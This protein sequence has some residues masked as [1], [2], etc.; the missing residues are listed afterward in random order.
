VHEW[1]GHN[2][3]ARRRAKQLAE[4]GYT[5]FAVDM[6]G[7]G[8]Q[9]DH[10]EDA[11]KFMEQVMSD[12]GMAR[13]RFTAALEIL[14]SHPHV[15]AERTG[16]IGYCFGGAVVLNM[17]RMGVDLDAVASFHGTLQSIVEEAPD[18]ID[19][20]ILVLNGAADPF[21]PDEQIEAFK[22]EMKAADADYEI[23]NYPGVKHAFTNPN[24]DDMG[25]KFDLPL[26]YD[27]EADEDSWEKMKA[28][29]E[30]V[31]AE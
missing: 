13:E 12:A 21:V 26:A 15:D 19:T 8:K 14:K 11:Q 6:Y 22:E 5:A 23:V 7:E 24:A 3:Y 30:K 29:F 1:W 17:A 25:E 2:D 20:D 31:F 28:F 4:A 9:A 10:P 18:S 16:A 27:A